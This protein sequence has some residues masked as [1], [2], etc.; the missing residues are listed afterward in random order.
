MDIVV[1]AGERRVE[2]LRLN[3][4][5]DTPSPDALRIVLEPGSA[6]DLEELHEGRASSPRTL[7][8]TLNWAG[9]PE[10]AMSPWWT[11]RAKAGSR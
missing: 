3:H 11:I 4:R 2:T 6:L 1:K 7:R 8:L 9:A 5:A 10:C